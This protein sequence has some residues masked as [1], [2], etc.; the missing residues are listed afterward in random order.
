MERGGGRIPGPAGPGNQPK[1]G[2]HGDQWTPWQARTRNAAFGPSFIQ[3][4]VFERGLDT[5]NISSV[6]SMNLTYLVD[7]ASS[8]MLVSKIKPCMC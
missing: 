1:K 6:L 7:P 5:S 3:R 2:P 4:A 8:H